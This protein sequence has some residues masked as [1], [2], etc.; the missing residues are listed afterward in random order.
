MAPGDGAWV[1]GLVAFALAGGAVYDLHQQEEASIIVYTTPALRDVLEKDIIPRWRDEG[2]LKVEPVYVAA[3]QQYNRLRMSGDRPEADLFL[4]ASPL[5]LE[6]GYDDG[7][8]ALINATGDDALSDSFQGDEAEGG[9]Y[10]W[11]AW[12]WSP[13]VEVYSPK[14]DEAPDLATAKLDYGLAHPTLSNNG[15]YTA[16]FFENASAAAGQHAKSRTVVQ[17]VN[18]RTNIIGVADG[19][20]DVTLG[21]EAVAEFFLGQHADIKYD[22]PLI[23]GRR[24]T[25]PVVF[26]AA[27]VEG[28]RHEEEARAFIDFLLRNDTQA[29]L[30]ERH[31][32]PV[33]DDGAPVEPMFAGVA[34]IRVD[35]GDWEAIE[36]IL[37]K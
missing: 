6:K 10:P 33:L 15:I 34:S 22:W 23:D 28:G 14:L 25:L 27:V 8:F 7:Y 11:V 1:A 2:G 4:H 24:V 26:C 29:A 37:G 3:G 17:P 12:S 32:R 35:W 20:F 21:Y 19:S 30:A 31:F 5:F 36:A 13:L 18:A 9:G 16:L